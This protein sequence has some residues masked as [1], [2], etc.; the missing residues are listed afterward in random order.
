MAMKGSILRGVYSTIAAMRPTTKLNIDA[1]A[2]GAAFS[3]STWVGEGDD[4][5]ASSVDIAYDRASVSASTCGLWTGQPLEARI[6][7]ETQ[8]EEGVTP[9]VE[10]RVEVAVGVKLGVLETLLDSDTVVEVGVAEGVV[11][12]VAL[13]LL[14]VLVLLVVLTV[15]EEELLLTVLELVET[16]VDDED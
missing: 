9:G 4:A 11:E 6:E 15:E 5:A 13:L 3:L 2:A 7:L 8:P 10:M 12:V 1:P 16:V 14:V